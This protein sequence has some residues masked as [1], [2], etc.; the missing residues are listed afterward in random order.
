[1]P[2]ETITFNNNEYPALQSKGFASHFSFPFA[3]AICKGKGYDIGYSKWDWKLAGAIGIDD[4]K[5]Y[6]DDIEPMADVSAT[7]LPY[8]EMDYIFSSHC[9][10]HLHDWVGVL[11]Y[12]HSKIKSGGVLFLYLPNCDIQEYWQPANNRKH[13]NH[14]N[15][16]VMKA[17]FNNRL[18]KFRNVFVT[19]GCDL[20]ASFYCIAEK[21]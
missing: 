16:K 13:V 11:D 21:V 20:N 18:D 4:G 9:L 19:P 15:P 17:Y 10:E 8:D 14:L 6:N 2:I 5:M 1:M 7:E 3:Q 12:W